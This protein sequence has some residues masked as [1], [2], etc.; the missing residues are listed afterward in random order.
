MVGVD[1][2]AGPCMG[3]CMCENCCIIYRKLPFSGDDVWWGWA[4]KCMCILPG[5]VRMDLGLGEGLDGDDEEVIGVVSGCEI[6][7]H[8]VLHR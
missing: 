2:Q 8:Q 3:R 7:K 4:K 6:L 1:G 5:L